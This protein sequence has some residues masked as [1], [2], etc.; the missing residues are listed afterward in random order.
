MSVAKA[1]I[2]TI[3]IAADLAAGRAPAPRPHKGRQRRTLSRAALPDSLTIH[4]RGPGG[5]RSL[6]AFCRDVSESGA[7]AFVRS[8]IPAPTVIELDLNLPDCTYTTRARVVFCRTA[9]GGYHVGLKFIFAEDPLEA[10][11]VPARRVREPKL[12]ADALSKHI[13]V[14]V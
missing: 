9:P 1:Q 10:S 7:G 6:E 3:E 5:R 2:L 8:P 12:S 13:A 4:L 11:A 14:L